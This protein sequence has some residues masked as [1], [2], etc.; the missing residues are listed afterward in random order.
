[1]QVSLDGTRRAHDAIRGEGSY[2]AAL[3][4]LDALKEHGVRTM[5]S[6]TA[7]RENCR[8]LTKLARVCDTLGV[9]KLWFD[10]VIIP[11][12][13]DEGHLTLSSGEYDRLLHTAARLNSR[14]KVACDRAL[15]FIYARDKRF[16]RCSAGDRLIIVLADGSV[17]PCRR[18]PLIAGNLSEHSLIELYRDSEVFRGLRGAPLPEG[19]SGCQYADRCHGGAKCLTYAKTGRYDLPDP[20]CPLAKRI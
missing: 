20:D 16:Y 3:R 5:V 19:C 8:E 7:Q 12:D 11:A 6:F 10:R 2:D 9:D 15:Q 13:E 18:I 1:M 4:G 17:M 14:D